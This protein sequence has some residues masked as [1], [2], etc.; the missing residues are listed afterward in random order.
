MGL[1]IGS[2]RLAPQPDAP[3]SAHAAA[4]RNAYDT[5]TVRW[6]RSAAGEF[7]F[8]HADRRPFHGPRP[9]PWSLLPPGFGSGPFDP[10]NSSTT[11]STIRQD[12]L[13]NDGDKPD[14]VDTLDN[15]PTVQPSASRRALWMAVAAASAVATAIWFR[16]RTTLP[17]A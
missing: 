6:V 4:Y 16:P 1:G 12:I 5:L 15:Q 14:I 8:L 11:S 13:D 7:P 3:A 10:D 2:E 17:A 9:G